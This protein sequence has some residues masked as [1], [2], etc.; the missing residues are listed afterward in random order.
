[1]GNPNTKTNVPY[2]QSSVKP[3]SLHPVIESSRH[4]VI[5]PSLGLT[6]LL[7]RQILIS[8]THDDC[9]LD[10]N[11]TSG[12]WRSHKYPWTSCCTNELHI[13]QASSSQPLLPT[14]A[15][16]AVI[17]QYFNPLLPL[18]G[19]LIFCQQFANT[20]KLF[21]LNC[22]PCLGNNQHKSLIIKKEPVGLRWSEAQ[23]MYYKKCK[24]NKD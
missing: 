17:A 2:S 13:D 9:S 4:L 14:A 21:L 16:C 18:S 11:S 1:M 3:S 6:G 22:P 15:I 10:V 8:S 19:K 20:Q 5:Q 7:H 23:F 12:V 24:P